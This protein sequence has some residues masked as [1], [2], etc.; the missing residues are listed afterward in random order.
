MGAW[1]RD[2]KGMLL[3]PDQRNQRAGYLLAGAISL[4]RIEKGWQL[5]AQPGSF[6]LHRGS[7]RLDPF[8]MF[9]ELA[10]GKIPPEE[11][12]ERCKE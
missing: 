10:G 12:R 5:E 8:A 2:P 4:A 7:E 3:A 1:I 9:G 6:Y 11:W